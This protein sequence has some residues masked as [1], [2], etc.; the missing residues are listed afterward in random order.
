MRK[1]QFRELWQKQKARLRDPQARKRVL[2]SVF[3]SLL[4]MLVA[5]GL[6][7]FW[8]LT[9]GLPDV[10]KLEQYDPAQTTK[11]YASDGTLIATLFDENRTPVT[12]DKISPLMREAIVSIEDRRFFEH[13]GVDWKGIA[14]AG[15]GNLSDGGVEQGASTLTMQLARRLYLSNER[16]YIRKLREAELA[17]RIDREL[18]KEKILELYLNE[19]YFGAGAYG[20][21][22]AAGVYFGANP[23]DLN[24]WQSALLAGL[25]Q[26]PS[27]YSPLVDREA[28]L[29]RTLEVLEAMDSRGVIPPGAVKKAMKE[30][31]AYNFVNHGVDGGDGMLK[32]PYFTTYVIAQLADV[33]PENYI[34]RGGLNIYTT[35]DPSLQETAEAV[36]KAEVQG[37]GYALGAQTGAVVVLDNKTGDIK[38]MVGGLDWDTKNQFNRA[39]Q[40]KRQPGSSFKTFVYA[41]ALED[42]YTPESEFADTEA[43]FD[44]PATQGWKPANSDGR[45]MGAVP[46]RTGLQFSRNVVAA[47]VMAHVGPER[48]VRLARRMGIEQELPAVISLALGAGEITPL[49]MARA[50]S[51]LPN[52]GILRP[53]LAITEVRDAEGELLKRFDGERARSSRA[54]STQTA[55]VMC[56]MLRRVVLAGTGTGA[57]IG[58]TWVAGKTGTTDSFVDAWFVGFT[59]HHT[60]SV[61][62]GRDDNKPMGRIYGGSLPADVFRKVAE[63]A[64]IGR[65][66]SAGL[67]G[68]A[69]DEEQRVT[70]C[71]DSTYLALPGCSRTYTESFYSGVLPTRDCPLHR[72][73]KQVETVVKLPD[74]TLVRTE[75]ESDSTPSPEVSPTEQLRD[76]RLDP[77]VVT[78]EGALI[79]YT[80]KVPKGKVKVLKLKVTKTYPTVLRATDRL[81]EQQVEEQPHLDVAE[82]DSVLY[83]D[84]IDEDSEPVEYT[85]SELPTTPAAGGEIREIRV[86]RPA[87]QSGSTGE[88]QAEVIYTNQAVEIPSDPLEE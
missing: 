49:E 18:S 24:L 33:F 11:I 84:T 1:V 19:V 71:W 58:G 81:S 72:Q 41:A 39:W 87:D 16:T 57:N 37:Q 17:R 25:V 68:V 65:S 56:E 76:P 32:F 85:E 7:V 50:Y 86:E 79:P 30:A 44:N 9:A 6:L 88:P 27:V 60:V 10:T 3:F 4:T 26:A 2:L 52:G 42:G 62:V 46:L 54:L 78:S 61:W 66:P 34:R 15:L 5:G 73:V 47:K 59:P 8:A 22:A 75:V 43:V 14:R 40:A 13:T 21:D 36:L 35:L 29:K 31:A 28:A 67:P 55:R 83:E 51:V 23:K 53:N 74:D 63:K 12:L 80:E 38:A 82:D 45:F 48:V 64:M 20:I 70:L 69:F 77:E